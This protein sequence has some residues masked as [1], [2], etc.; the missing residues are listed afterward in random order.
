MRRCV[1]SS[2]TSVA[3]MGRR[4]RRSRS[5]ARTAGTEVI[6]PAYNTVERAPA[7]PVR[8][9]TLVDR[10]EYRDETCPLCFRPLDRRVRG[11]YC[12]RCRGWLV[13][14]VRGG[15]LTHALWQGNP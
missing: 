13:V 8:R 9:L 1:G 6:V 4:V 11:L 10:E 2:T 14:D 12:P 7:A 5:G 15:T 3:G